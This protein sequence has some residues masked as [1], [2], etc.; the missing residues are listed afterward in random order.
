MQNEHSVKTR[1]AE[2]RA[3]YMLLILK[4]ESEIDF[5]NNVCLVNK[6]IYQ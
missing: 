4:D 5:E 1:I 6:I 2:K 3:N